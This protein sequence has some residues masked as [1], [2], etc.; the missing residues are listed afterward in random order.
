MNKIL[1]KEPSKKVDER[2][3]QMEILS[4]SFNEILRCKETQMEAKNVFR[5]LRGKDCER[6]LCDSVF[7]IKT[8][9]KTSGL[10]CSLL[11]SYHQYRIKQ[12]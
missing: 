6:Y 11:E 12:L 7:R 3:Q 1:I 2:L 4:E 10:M 5:Y 8:N 9:I